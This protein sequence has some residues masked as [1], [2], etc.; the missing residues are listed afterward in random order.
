LS[1]FSSYLPSNK[2]GF[3]T[4]LT[5][6]AFLLPITKRGIPLVIAAMA[7]LRIWQAITGDPTLRDAGKI[8]RQLAIVMV[9]YFALHL[10]GMFWTEDV[11]SGWKEIEYKLSFAVFPLLLGW[12][13]SRD[14]SLP[15]KAF[16]AFVA[17]N[18]VYMIWTIA[19]AAWRSLEGEESGVWFYS[20]LS[21]HFHPSYTAMY[22]SFALVLW[23]Y[24]LKNRQW[25]WHVGAAVAM[26]L[27]TGLLSSKAGMVSSGMALCIAGLLLWQTQRKKAMIFL[28]ISLPLFAINSL[29]SPGLSAR[30]NA[31]IQDSKQA[32]E[33]PAVADTLASA[34]STNLRM[35]AL[36]AGM[37]AVLE[38][39]FGAGTGDLDQAMGEQYVRQGAL[40]AAEKKLN[41][42]N[43]V[44]STGIAL[45]WPGILILMAML[46][47]G[48]KSAWRNRDYVFLG[49]MFIVAMNLMFESMLEM[50]GG[51]VFF[52]FWMLILCEAGSKRI[53]AANTK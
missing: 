40:F 34:S 17:G 2:A 23:V 28:A 11:G 33:A 20:E 10:F 1:R 13:I 16:A 22:V 6:M 42:H 35:S 52:C 32:Q 44:L 39:P 31:A 26:L 5:T 51:I 27:Y 8:C 37:D 50:Q 46:W 15:A 4:L 53:A 45:G 29:Y 49:F 41:P 25:W 24:L 18:V 7:I 9:A 12:K 30:I 3:D 43:Q 36:H 48:F 38:H 19:N 21:M 47:I 14:Q